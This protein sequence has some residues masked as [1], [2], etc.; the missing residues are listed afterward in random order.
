M[1]NTKLNFASPEPTGALVSQFYLALEK[2]FEMKLGEI[3]LI[4]K[5]GDVSKHN[6]ITSEN[7]EQ[8][9]L[10]EFSDDNDLTDSHLNFWN[11]LKN[12]KDPKFDSSKYKYLIL[13]TTQDIGVNSKLLTW[14]ES[15]FAERNKI[16]DEIYKK[17]KVRFEKAKTKDIK[18]KES[19]SLKLMNLVFNDLKALEQIIN[20]VVI[21]NKRTR[22]DKIAEEI[23][24]KYLKFIPL[25]S[26][27]SALNLILGY[28]VREELY[29]KGWEINY[30]GFKKE[31][32]DL[33]SRFNNETKLFPINEELK[34]IPI[35]EIEKTKK[36]AF[37]K[38]IEDINYH[39]EIPKSLNDYWFT[40]NTI[41][42]EFIG[43]KQKE[44]SFQSFEENLITIHNS[45]HKIASRDTNNSN[46]INNSQNFYDKIIGS[47]VPG[48]DVYNDTPLIF[49]NGMYHILANDE[50]DKIIWKLNTKK[51]E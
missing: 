49:K 24:E 37:V 17:A 4:E 39:E 3:V 38:K 16:L 28:I 11:T 26:Q 41:T 15:N 21:D 44:A 12:W 7:G 40:L 46:I 35:S 23:I 32:E 9:E 29:N 51:N 13:A 6:P 25:K 10:K 36:Y 1:T 33:S 45:E 27:E 14:N 18:A 8:L 50:D 48:F 19:D 34:T 47:Q 30:D 2:C 22:R 42:K 31:L 5:D 20:K 43:R